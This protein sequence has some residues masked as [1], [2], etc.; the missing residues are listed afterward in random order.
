MDLIPAR[1]GASSNLLQFL[2]ISS[3]KHIPLWFPGA[4]FRRKAHEWSRT[5]VELV[6][7]PHN[8]VKQQLVRGLVSVFFFWCV[9]YSSIHWLGFGQ[10]TCVLRINVTEPK[11]AKC[12]RRI[13][14]EVECS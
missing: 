14:P 3:V 13:R 10:R 11:K 2:I 9:I 7:R 1:K 12:G 6:E 4:G 5:L 8:F